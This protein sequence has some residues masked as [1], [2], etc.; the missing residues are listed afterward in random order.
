MGENLSDENDF[1]R[2]WKSIIGQVKN[3]I[4]SKTLGIDRG[5]LRG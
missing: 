1:V 3:R 2:N 5:H 4:K